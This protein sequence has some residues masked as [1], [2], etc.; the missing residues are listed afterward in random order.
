MERSGRASVFIPWPSCLDA[1]TQRLSIFVSSLF[2]ICDSFRFLAFTGDKMEENC[3]TLTFSSRPPN[4]QQHL[5]GKDV[6][7]T[8]EFLVI[9]I[10]CL[11]MIVALGYYG[12]VAVITFGV[13]TLVLVALFILNVAGFI[14]QSPPHRRILLCWVTSFPMVSPF[15]EYLFT[16]SKNANH[17][18]QGYFVPGVDDA[19]HPEGRKSLRHGETNVY[20]ISYI[21]T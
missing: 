2:Y 6:K 13:T 11:Y 4:V 17:V 3:S 7:I 10:I 1:A 14:R 19:A 18:P 12:W 21:I 20:E 9:K 15:L 8:D 5:E 16:R